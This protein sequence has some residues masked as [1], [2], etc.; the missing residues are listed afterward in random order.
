MKW[1]EI[2][3]GAEIDD[4]ATAIVFEANTC[5]E[6]VRA[7]FN[8]FT[9]IALP[10]MTDEDELIAAY[11]R[12]LSE[13]F[14]RRSADQGAELGAEVILILTDLLQDLLASALDR[15]TYESLRRGARQAVG[16]SASFPGAGI[17][18]IKAA[19]DV[20]ATD[21]A[22]GRKFNNAQKAMLFIAAV[23]LMGERAGK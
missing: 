16:N 14:R 11:Y 17:S 6:E 10:H 13:A 3:P 9:L 1:I 23:E 5:G 20:Y 21:A 4:A 22:N 7:K 19:R 15:R 18:H 2:D 12:H 8:S